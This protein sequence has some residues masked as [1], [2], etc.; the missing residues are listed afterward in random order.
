MQG[1]ISNWKICV[2]IKNNI[3]EDLSDYKKYQNNRISH[4]DEVAR[5]SGNWRGFS[6]YYHKR[7]NEVLQ[8][9]VP[10]GQ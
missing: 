1:G 8:F 6:G 7:L 9:V 3:Q 2:M 10:S 5:K 4:W